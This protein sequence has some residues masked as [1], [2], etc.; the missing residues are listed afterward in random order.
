MRWSTTATVVGFVLLAAGLGAI[1]TGSP[2]VG[3]AL[4]MLAI[5]VLGV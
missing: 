2:W 1:F 3:F 4:V 5:F